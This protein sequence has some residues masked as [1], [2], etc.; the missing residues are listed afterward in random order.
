MRE[1]RELN[2]S[3]LPSPNSFARSF[4][5]AHDCVPSLPCR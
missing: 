1:S 5:D 4:S 2:D 3:L